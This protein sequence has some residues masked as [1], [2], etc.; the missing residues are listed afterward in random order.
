MDTAYL[1][2]AIGIMAV[3][4]YIPRMVPLALFR[5]KIKNPFICSLLTYMPYSILAAMVFPDIFTSTSHLIS[6]IAGTAVALILAYHKRSLL[7][8]ALSA[9]GT[10]FI[11]EQLLKLC[12]V[13]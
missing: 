3:V 2:I 6:G 1:A 13:I 8:V 9:T 12:N 5:K 7:T 10:V 11:C 4:T